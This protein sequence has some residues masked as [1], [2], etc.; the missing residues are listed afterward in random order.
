MVLCKGVRVG[1]G[2]LVM[3]CGCR[4][5]CLVGVVMM[6]SGSLMCI[7]CGCLLLNMVKVWVSI[8]GSFLV[9]IRVWLKV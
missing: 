2:W 3:V 9:F 6:L 4:V 8:V 1:V 7:G 5:R